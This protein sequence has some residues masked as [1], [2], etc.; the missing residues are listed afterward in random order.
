MPR[1]S[2]WIT[3]G[4]SLLYSIYLFSEHIWR[5]GFPDGFVS[6]L[7]RGQYYLAWIII[8]ACL[9]IVSVSSKPHSFATQFRRVF[10][11]L[12]LGNGGLYLLLPSLLLGSA[13]G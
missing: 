7:Q 4:I 5:L 9:W 8:G 3:I 10:A 12:L 11:L 6:P 13:G 1:S 2:T